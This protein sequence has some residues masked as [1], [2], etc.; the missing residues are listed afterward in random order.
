MHAIKLHVSTS[1][2]HEIQSDRLCDHMQAHA[3]L[4]RDEIIVELRLMLNAAWHNQ[5]VSAEQGGWVL[6]RT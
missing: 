6:C 1:T 4:R 2:P 5:G 3:R